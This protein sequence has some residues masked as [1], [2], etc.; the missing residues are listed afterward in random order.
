M[1]GKKASGNFLIDQA[2]LVASNV[3]GQIVPGSG[4]WLMEEAPNTVIPAIIDFLN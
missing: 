1:P 4:Y 2:R 3:T